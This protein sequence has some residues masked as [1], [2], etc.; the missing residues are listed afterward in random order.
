MRTS[1]Q[2]LKW[3]LGG[4][5]HVALTSS[6]HSATISTGIA[7]RERFESERLHHDVHVVSKMP[8]TDDRI[9][10]I[11]SNEQ[12]PQVRPSGSCC[13]GQL[14][15]IE[16]VWQADVGDKQIDRISGIQNF[17]RSCAVRGINGRVAKLAQNLPRAF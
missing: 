16:T 6:F 7:A 13:I 8:M 2:G 12:H 10:C 11:A 4:S 9:F 5:R 14:A 1:D 15:S 17:K 3:I